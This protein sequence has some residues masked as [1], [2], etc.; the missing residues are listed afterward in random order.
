MTPEPGPARTGGREQRGAGGEKLGVR[1]AGAAVLE[2]CKDSESRDAP[3][4][5]AKIST[6]DGQPCRSPNRGDP[7]S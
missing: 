2:R 3:R 7:A 1:G 5:S 6:L 4:L